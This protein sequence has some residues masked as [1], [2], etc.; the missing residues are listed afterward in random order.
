[1]RR[2][3]IC[4]GFPITHGFQGTARGS[5]VQNREI[6]SENPYEK[7]NKMVTKMEAILIG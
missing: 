4:T 5:R 6:E 1:M 7:V 3:P 2:A